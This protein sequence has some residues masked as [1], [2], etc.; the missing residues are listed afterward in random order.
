MGRPIQPPVETPRALVRL[1]MPSH[2]DIA[3]KANAPLPFSVAGLLSARGRSETYFV[4][5]AA[6]SS[7]IAAFTFACAAFTAASA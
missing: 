4:F 2:V 7:A 1:A 6:F 5:F 3:H